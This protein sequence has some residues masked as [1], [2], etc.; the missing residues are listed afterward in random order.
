VRNCGKPNALFG[1]R[2]TPQREKGIARG[3]GLPRENIRE[4]GG[5]EDTRAEQGCGRSSEIK[6]FRRSWGERGERIV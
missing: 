4:R 6:V 3:V 5:G 1:T 2:L